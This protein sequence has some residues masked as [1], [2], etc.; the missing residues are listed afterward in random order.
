MSK[1]V[2]FVFSQFCRFLILGCFVQLFNFLLL[3]PGSDSRLGGA[4]SFRPLR[5]KG[6][7]VSHPAASQRRC[8]QRLFQRARWDCR[9]RRLPAHEQT[10]SRGFNHWFRLGSVGRRASQTGPTDGNCWHFK[11]HEGLSHFLSQSACASAPVSGVYKPPSCLVRFQV[12][13]MLLIVMQSAHLVAQRKAFQQSMEDVLTL[14]REQTSS[15]P[16][17]ASALEELKVLE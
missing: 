4:P 14:S 9:R 17:I 7:A 11:S 1:C 12:E 3:Y 5:H 15:Q 2:F 16:L 6:P 10:Q 8:W 13:N